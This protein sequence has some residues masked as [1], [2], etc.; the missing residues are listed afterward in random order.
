[1]SLC[2]DETFAT[3][4]QANSIVVARRGL[5]A[6]V[7]S[8]RCDRQSVCKDRASRRVGAQRDRPVRRRVLRKT[9]AGS[10][11]WCGAARYDEYRND[12]FISR[13]SPPSFR[14]NLVAPVIPINEKAVSRYTVPNLPSKNVQAVFQDSEG[15][16]WF[17][18]DKG[19]ARFNGAEFKS[20]AVARSGFERLAGDD[21][22]SIAE[23]KNGIIWIATARGVRRITKTGEKA[24]LHSITSKLDDLYRSR[25]AVGRG[26]QVFSGSMS[27]VSF[28]SRIR[29][30]CPRVT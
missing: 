10:F 15:W 24:G 1:M 23:D 5:D 13:A 14:F 25:G 3:S 29:R 20:S 8:R 30:N 28:L 26:L 18:T 21:V 11:S 22:R 7:S 17:G 16:M 9:R 19:I 27:A 12:V 4:D 6:S 2:A